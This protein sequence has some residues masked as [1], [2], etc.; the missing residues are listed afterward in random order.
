MGRE[1]AWRVGR[2][3]GEAKV[4]D[5]GRVNPPWVRGGFVDPGRGLAL[6]YPVKPKP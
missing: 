4:A 6:Q 1:G 3:T 5:S 2:E